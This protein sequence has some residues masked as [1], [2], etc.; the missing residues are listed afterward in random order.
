MAVVCILG[1]IVTM[2]TFTVI[3][4][5]GVAMMLLGCG[6]LSDGEQSLDSEP[7]T[8]SAMSEDPK[9]GEGKSPDSEPVVPTVA[10]AAVSE[11][12]QFL[13]TAPII[14]LGP[15]SLEERILAYPV[16]AR[17]RLDSTT[18]TTESGTTY[19]GQKYL[20]I[21]EF[22]FSV[23]EYLKGSGATNIV[24]VWAAAPFFDT[25]QEAEA[26]LPDIVAIRDNQW[27]NREAIVFLQNSETH[28]PSTEQADRY[29]L[30]WGGSW[31]I[32]D[33]GYSIASLHNK[34]WLPATAAV[35]APSQPSGDQQGFLLDV[36][37]ATGTASTITLGEM[38]SRIAGVAAKL[39][40]G[41]DSEEYRECVRL[42]YEYEA[43]DRHYWATYPD[44]SGSVYGNAPP[45]E[46]ELDSGLAM[47]SVLYEDDFGLGQTADKTADKLNPLWLDGGDAAVFNV[48]YDKPIPYD[49][50]GDG[51]HDSFKFT[52]QIA[53]ARPLPE[54]V[55]QF[56][57]NFR[58]TIFV[59][60]DGHTDR[61]EWTVTVNAP[62]GVLHE[63]FFDPVT[64]GTAV[65]A[66][67]TNPST[68]S[69]QAGVLEPATFTDA[70]SAS[71]TIE[72]IAWEPGPG[73]SG[74]VKLKL[75]PHTGIAGHTVNFSALDGSVSL[76]LEVA[77]A[78]VDATTG[79]LSWTVELQPWQSGDKLMLRVR[80]E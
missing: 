62:E 9:S 1:G 69:G 48:E 16:I 61:Y 6:F 63:S 45:H 29:Y 10:P 38:K 78:T 58:G 79:T 57:Y 22:N 71:A 68:G 24:A 51:V 30:E 39:N 80:E 34:L 13:G 4:S 26:A 23:Q 67:S 56:H 5:F 73:G 33:D 11:G 15:T 32:P 50:S 35:G 40:A 55:Y 17:V 25:R 8:P 18:S 66:D 31:T 49:F 37:P 65:A 2:R 14:Y 41:D 47:G 54:G 28:L 60:C 77:A 7:V 27:D 70:N 72:R 19:E 42:T 21:L 12:E 44:R 46:H 20:A 3:L 74:T 43:R 36:P 64:D 75:S 53:S 76:S 59:P 52:R